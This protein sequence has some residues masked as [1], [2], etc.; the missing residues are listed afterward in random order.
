[1]GVFSDIT[2]IRGGMLVISDGQGQ[3]CCVILWTV[4]QRGEWSHNPHDFHMFCQV[5]KESNFVLHI[6]V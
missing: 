4:L 6:N 5:F 1:M 3:S 2:V